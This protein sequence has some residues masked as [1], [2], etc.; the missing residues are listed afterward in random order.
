MSS[1]RPTC[2]GY[3]LDYSYSVFVLCCAVLSGCTPVHILDCLDE[4]VSAGSIY[5][6]AGNLAEPVSVAAVISA[7]TQSRCATSWQNVDAT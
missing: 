4:C 6:Q 5:V 2:Y 7:M 3:L 1:F